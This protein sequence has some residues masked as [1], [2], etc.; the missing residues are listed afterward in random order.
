MRKQKANH[1]CDITNE[2]CTLLECHCKV[3]AVEKRNRQSKEVGVFQLLVGRQV[4]PAVKQGGQSC[5]GNLP[6]S[7][8]VNQGKKVPE[9]GYGK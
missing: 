4:G 3:G 9:S 6:G 1:N 7:K 5:E 8:R 2:L